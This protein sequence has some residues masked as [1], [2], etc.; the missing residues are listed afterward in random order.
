[1]DSNSPDF[2]LGKRFYSMIS[3]SSFS[4]NLQIISAFNDIAGEDVVLASAFRLLSSQPVV[5]SVF[6][7]ITNTYSAQ[8]PAIKA[9]AR[10][11]LS[12]QLAARFSDFF[13][14]YFSCFSAN[15]TCSY[16]EYVQTSPKEVQPTE[17]I[18]E[19]SRFRINESGPS[20]LF[21]SQVPVG[22]QTHRDINSRSFRANTSSQFKFQKKFFKPLLLM[23]ILLGLGFSALKFKVMCEPLGLCKK[24]PTKQAINTPRT[25]PKL[26]PNSMPNVPPSKS[27][28]VPSI[29]PIQPNVPAKQYDPVP[30][31]YPPVTPKPYRQTASPTPP[32]AQARDEPLW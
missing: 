20:T 18:S 15:S 28:S 31:V 12:Q 3:G 8:L 10:D 6:N 21:D 9:L 24:T 16:S 11:T 13:E 4:N 30:P 1:M 17:I 22:T 26:N 14:G 19:G 27:E 25:S 7:K 5:L 32:A 23:L 2:L 29:S